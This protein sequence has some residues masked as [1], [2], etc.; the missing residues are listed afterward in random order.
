M[1]PTLAF[2]ENM[3]SFWQEEELPVKPLEQLFQSHLPDI[4]YSLGLVLFSNEREVVSQFVSRLSTGLCLSLAA[5]MRE[6]VTSGHPHGELI[7]VLLE[8]SGTAALAAQ[9]RLVDE[10][11]GWEPAVPPQRLWEQLVRSL[12]HGIRR[13]AALRLSAPEVERLTQT[14]LTEQSA[15]AGSSPTDKLV[16]NALVFSCGHNTTATAFHETAM[17]ELEDS[18]LKRLQRP[19]PLTAKLLARGYAMPGVI[20]F[21]CPRCVVNEIRANW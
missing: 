3:V 18:L 2:F 1:K 13:K 17:P 19:L 6:R 14:L 11:A 21:A 15:K 4:G 20:P 10:S 5:A 12:G 9:I 8:K 16:G 7:G